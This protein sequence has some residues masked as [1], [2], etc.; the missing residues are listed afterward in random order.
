MRATVVTLLLSSVVFAAQQTSP[1]TIWS[2]VYTEAQAARGK[3]E[4]DRACRRCHASNLD[5]IQDA[6][7]LGDL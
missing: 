2:G 7:L 3:A 6:N 1:K 4:Y 5:G